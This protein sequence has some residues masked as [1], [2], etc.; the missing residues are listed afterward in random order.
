[1]ASNLSGGNVEL[2]IEDDITIV[3][4]NLSAN[5][6]VDETTG[7]T[8]G[9][10]L[11]ITAGGDLNILAGYNADYSKYTKKTSSLFSSKGMHH[12]ESDMLE[13]INKNWVASNLLGTNI[14]IRTGK[15]TNIIGSNIDAKNSVSLVV[16]EHYDNSGNLIIGQDAKLNILALTNINK[17]TREHHESYN[18]WGTIGSA[19]AGG[20]TGGAT[21]GGLAGCG[22]GA[23]GG[24]MD[25]AVANNDQYKDYIGDGEQTI[26][27]TV[28][29]SSIKAG[30]NIELI[31]SGDINLDASS[32]DAN[33]DATIGA[34][35]QKEADGTF[36]K[37]NTDAKLNKTSR[38]NTTSIATDEYED[39]ANLA[40]IFAYQYVKQYAT[41]S[42]TGVSTRNTGKWPIG[43]I[44]I[45]GSN[46]YGFMGGKVTG[47]IID[48]KSPLSKQKEHELDFS[49]PNITIN[50][51]INPTI[52]IKGYLNVLE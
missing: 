20:C 4:S 43:G 7:E 8:T 49:N 19:I 26:I 38:Q 24:F 42:I 22:A 9:G 45:L 18:S 10:N 34:G 2:D 16:G 11:D 13:T 52:D 5:A 32:I 50:K 30:G 40:N 17:T 47:L 48:G 6:K 44:K 14:N 21:A 23:A 29:S 31:S 1:M 27:K 39:K 12:D 51:I 35:Y 28:A 37:I 41:V 36:T 46:I 25:S 33:G 15:N 3:G